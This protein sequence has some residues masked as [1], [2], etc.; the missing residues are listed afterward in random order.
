MMYQLLLDAQNNCT[1][2]PTCMN[3]TVDQYVKETIVKLID[4]RT[5][6]SADLIENMTR[7]PYCPKDWLWFRRAN[8]LKW[9]FTIH[10][11]TMNYTEGRNYC[12]NQNAVLNG[13]ESQE[14][15][16]NFR[17]RVSN[18]I[19]ENTTDSFVLL[20]AERDDRNLCL[21]S[22]MGDAGSRATCKYQSFTWFPDVSRNSTIFESLMPADFDG[23]GP[24]F[25]Y[26]IYS[27]QFDD[28]DCENVQFPSCGRYA[29][30]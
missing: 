30:F 26:R 17:N 20:G 12:E 15:A 8:G 4:T 18:F 13:F 24:C 29:P 28:F 2:Y 22:G 25:Q 14:E 9:C 5:D 16:D 6:C 10:N 7:I 3:F 1:Y 23:S 19:T 11:E 21:G 27:N